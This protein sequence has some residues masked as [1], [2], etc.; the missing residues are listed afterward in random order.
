MDRFAKTI[1]P[2]GTRVVTEHVPAIRSVSIG[3]WVEV[4]SRDE[5]P[6]QN[7]ISHFIEHMHFKRTKRRTALQIAQALE[8]LG[9]TINAFT[10]REHTCYYVRI[11][12]RHLPVAMDVLGD[13]LNNS[14]FTPTDLKKEKSVVAEEIKDIADTPSE[15]VHDLFDSRMWKSNSLG[16]PI[17]GTAKNVRALTRSDVVG[18]L[19]DHYYQGPNIVVAAT[20]DVSHAALVRLARRHFR[21][22][23]TR[24]AGEK[25]VPAHNGFS[26][27]AFRR[28]TEQSQVCLGFPSI[29]FADRDR[30]PILAANAYLSGGMSSR[31]FQSVREKKGL[32]Y[33]IYSYQEFFRDSGVF[34]V[35]FG[36]DAKYVTKATNLVLKELCRMKERKLSATEL[37]EIKEQLKGNLVLSQES[38]YNRMNRIARLELMLG[39]QVNLDKTLKLI[40]RIT[41]EQ[42]RSIANRVFD[43]DGLTMCTL[44]QTKQAELEKVTW[45]AL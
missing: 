30:Y 2:N 27:K 11:L 36:A 35:Y 8:A 10:A 19:R 12:N 13:I 15:Y 26:V 40:D 17:M 25:I 22:P 37:H 24:P 6:R 1:L 16:Q 38:M 33:T 21:W 39:K 28:K 9:G 14:L 20:G 31:L 41:P 23:D 45:T 32:C 4:G 5:S 43:L 18:F 34:C 42:V 3:V 44:G 7:G 29:S